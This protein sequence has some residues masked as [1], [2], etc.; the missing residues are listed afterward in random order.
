MSQSRGATLRKLRAS[1]VPAALQLSAE[2]GWNQTLEDWLMLVDLAPEGCL[3]IEIDAE[4]VSTATL[5]CYGRRLAWLGMV[6]TRVAYRGQGFARRLLT[7]ALTIVDQMQ[8]ETVK[9]DAT[10][11]GQ[12][13][14]EKLGFRGEQ[15][16]E[17]WE[18]P[19]S[20]NVPSSGLT[21]NATPPQDWQAADHH[22]FGLDRSELLERLARRHAPFSV[23]CSYLLTRAGRLTTYLGPCVAETPQ[24]ART[25][26]GRALE[27]ASTGGWSWDLFPANANAVALAQEFAFTPRRHL[28][29]MVRGKDFRGHEEAIYAIAG[30]ELG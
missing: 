28:L 13:L 23:S 18:R 14:Y 19:A 2:A 25:L 27:T 16:V 12:Q 3:A 5:L 10:D 20:A 9:L 29:R 30:F 21:S 4:V 22:A 15:P 17:R 11:Q 7:E 6:L 26:I 8:I 1:D 24:C